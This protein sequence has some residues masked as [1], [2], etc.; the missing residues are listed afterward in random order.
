MG[1]CMSAD[2]EGTEMWIEQR[3]GWNRDVDGTEMWMEQRCGWDRDPTAAEIRLENIA[4]CLSLA[5]PLLTDLNDAFAPPFVPSIA[6][7]IQ[8]M[9]DSVQNVK[10]N[11][12]ECARLMD[13]LHEVLCA[14]INVYMKSETVGSLPPSMLDN[15]GKFTKF[16]WFVPHVLTQTSRRTL[17]KIYMF[18]EAQQEGNKLKQLFRSNEMNLLLRECHAGLKLAI[19]VFGIRIGSLNDMREFRKKADIMHKELI[20]LIE[21]LSD[22]STLSERSSPKIFYGH[23]LELEKVLKLLRQEAPRIA[24]LGG[25]GMGKTS[26][27]RTVLHHPDTSTRFQHRFFTT[28]WVNSGERSHKARCPVLFKKKSSCLLVLDNLETVWESIESRTSLE[29]FLAHLTGLEHLG[30]MPL[31]NSAARQTFLD[32]TDNSETSEAIDQLLQFTDNMPLAVDL[33][34][35]LADH[36]GISNVTSRW[37]T[38]KTSLL[39]VGFDRRSNLD[40]SIGL[41]LSSPQITDDSKE[42]LSLLSVLPNGL[43]EAELVHINLAIPNILSCKAV[44]QATALGY[45][46]GNKWLLL[47]MPVREYIQ[48]FLPP[49]QSSMHLI[50]LHLYALLE[51]YNTYK[52][53]QLRPVV[54]QI[55]LNLANFHEILERGLHSGHPHLAATIRCTSSLNSFYRVTGRGHTVLMDFVRDILSEVHDRTVETAFLI[56]VLMTRKYHSLVSADL[57]VQQATH[58]DCIDDQLLKSKFYEAA[59]IYSIARMS[60]FNF[61]QA[62]N[63]FQ[64]ALELAQL[65]EDT[66]QQAS[67]LISRAGTKLSAGEYRAARRDGITAQRLA[68]L[69]GNFQLAARASLAREL[70]GMCAVG[71]TQ[72]NVFCNLDAAREIMSNRTSQISVSICDVIQ[73]IV[74]LREGKFNSAKMKFHACLRG[75]PWGIYEESAHLALEYLANVEAWAISGWGYEWPMGYIALLFL[76]DLF[77]VNKDEITAANLYEVALHGFTY[78]DVH[79]SRAQC[80]LRLGDLA[81]NQGHTSIAITHWEA[82]RPLFERASQAKDVA[83]IDSRLSTIKNTYHNNI[84][85]LEILRAPIGLVDQPVLSEADGEDSEPK[86]PLIVT[87]WSRSVELLELFILESFMGFIFEWKLSGSSMFWPT[88]EGDYFSVGTKMCWF[89][90]WN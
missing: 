28:C 29:E 12:N 33:I 32:I 37:E 52:G 74:E 51:L 87:S 57:L 63:F 16:C 6:N 31:S 24:I 75:L 62:T 90:T 56:E 54:N 83:K 38:E 48:Q 55:A 22:T 50:R 66:N 2:V 1:T 36:D 43:S 61:H 5:L 58:V 11:K 88:V 45:Q 78:M 15:I 77:R 30:L 81:N 65:C 23:E 70:I 85:K 40:I 9:I 53:E 44:L 89:S 25:G 82:A 49:S 84:V 4:A 73:A 80:M 68:E 21:T 34:A 7:T 20:Q 39:S 10:R 86:V 60:R 35:H 47:L 42:L 79:Q 14:I 8:A 67:V 41:S 46:D 27:A 64:R 19:D 18:V 59:G 26:L 17:H 72:D 3:Y 69:S 13:D 71:E 76:A